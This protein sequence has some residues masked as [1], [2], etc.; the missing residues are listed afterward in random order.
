MWTNQPIYF[1]LL[2]L[3]VL[4]WVKFGFIPII[5]I[6]ALVLLLCGWSR[7]RRPQAWRG[8]GFTVGIRNNFRE[9]HWVEYC[10]GGRTLALHAI[11]AA[12]KN[13]GL[14]VEIDQPLYFPPDYAHPLSE[15]RIVEI[16]QRI[17]E[18]LGH[19]RI[20]HRLIR[21]GQSVTDSQSKQPVS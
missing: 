12:A 10:E 13:G 16:E 5:V 8:N 6:A 9:E 21:V 14:N 17:S 7:L 4:I 1:V 15:E 2:I 11:W 18:G 3:G 20:S 19:L